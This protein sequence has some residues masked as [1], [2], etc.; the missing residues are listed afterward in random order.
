VTASDEL[1]EESFG[2]HAHIVV[3]WPRPGRP[4]H[5]SLYD[6]DVVGRFVAGQPRLVEVDPAELFATQTWVVRSH[7]GYYLT[8]E[9]ERTGRTSADMHQR[10]NRYPL[11]YADERG[12]LII[13]AGHHR[14]MAAR[15]EGRPVLARLVGSSPDAG[16]AVTP[17]VIDTNRDLDAI[18]DQLTVNGLTVPEIDER[19]RFAGLSELADR[20]E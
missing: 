6:R 2:S 3:P 13:L 10:A 11:I 9:W 1:L 15:I 8:G 14:S 17:S 20:Q 4:K 19:L 16:V 5:T 7:V 18:R 12:R